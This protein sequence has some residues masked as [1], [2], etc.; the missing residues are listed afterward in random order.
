M[1]CRCSRRQSLLE[2]DAPRPPRGL[3]ARFQR[4]RCR[5]A[6]FSKDDRA[7]NALGTVA[8]RV[9]KA[10][11]I[12]NFDAITK[13][14]PFAIVYWVSADGSKSEVSKTRT[15]Y[16]GHMS[17]VWEH[18]CR[19]QYYCTGDHIEIAV[20]ERDM[21]TNE[22]CGRAIVSVN[23]LC[24][25]GSEEPRSESPSNR[26]SECSWEVQPRQSIG[27]LQRLPLLL[28]DE[29]TGHVSIQALVRPV[30]MGFWDAAPQRADMGPET[31]ESPA[32][33]LGVSGG[34]APFYE[35]R[36][37]HP[38]AGQSAGHF[39]GKDL[40]H[41]SDEIHFYEEARHE[42]K[43]P[44][45]ESLAPL[46]AFMFEYAGLA[47]LDVE[48]GGIKELL[49]MRNLCDGHTKLRM[50]DIKIGQVTAQAGWQG[51]S[52]LAALRQ[53]IVDGLTNSAA[54]GFRLEGFD[55]R[56]PALCSMDPLLDVGNFT[57]SWNE[58][59]VKKANR[60][61]LQRL[62]AND[63]LMHFFDVHQVPEDP[64][65]QVESWLT[66]IEVAEI[67]HHEMA[68]KLLQLAV[69]CRKCHVPQKWIGS[70]VALG[71]ECGRLPPRCA[72]S[73]EDVR[74]ATHVNI[75]DWGRSELN[76]LAKHT[77]LSDDAQHDRSKF[78]VNYVGGVDR[79]AWEAMRAYYQ[80]FCVHT[81]WGKI[82]LSVYDFDSMTQ[83]DFI[84]RANIPLRETTGERTL[85]LGSGNMAFKLT[86]RL[87]WR[88]LPKGSRIWGT[89]RLHI[90][91]ASGVPAM[92]GP[93]KNSSDP[94]CEI[95]AESVTGN[96]Q[97][98]QVTCVKVADCN[99]TWDEVFDLPVASSPGVIDAILDEVTPS[100]GNRSVGHRPATEELLGPEGGDP[101]DVDLARAAWRAMLDDTLSFEEAMSSGIKRLNVPDPHD[102]VPSRPVG[103]DSLQL[104]GVHVED[105]PEDR[106]MDV[107]RP[108]QDL[109][110]SPPC[111][112]AML[113]G[114]KCPLA[115]QLS[116][117]EPGAAH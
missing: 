42:L 99:P 98:R 103:Q 67:S 7:Q 35:L 23:E 3:R 5:T 4:F 83:N 54:E 19:S 100:T 31:F 55:G 69:A 6:S 34:T 24:C 26:Q 77:I 52:R 91:S 1:G 17:P 22:F 108:L 65:Y 94:F 25:A 36:L 37:R 53:C 47:K 50:L 92:D 82:T 111:C 76:T 106:E 46:L 41:A 87:D 30:C 15:D 104:T 20:F 8:L 86:Y 11:L 12:R 13:M 59:T 48:C 63:M 85:D 117:A 14:D 64:G 113:T 80:K 81:K 51:K 60:M 2:A 33:R 29:V 75:F 84:G 78:W 74:R 43:G 102:L 101:A 89:W 45:G 49:V 109:R 105:G 71:F 57:G 116:R 9:M 95:V 16:G 18:T 21:L 68:R 61:M 38:K 28:G 44:E 115:P 72:T 40:A 114:W 70:S 62:S 90:I 58:K 66:P 110:P 96:V 73:E 27:M 10:D 97:L 79:L 112:A 39:L 88:K 107:R 56:P 93:L 32:K